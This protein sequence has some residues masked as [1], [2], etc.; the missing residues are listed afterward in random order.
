[1]AEVL[2]PKRAASEEK[3]AR[4]GDHQQQIAMEK[5]RFSSSGSGF[6]LWNPPKKHGLLDAPQVDSIN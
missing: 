3:A 4:G 6:C 5:L 2:R 1:M